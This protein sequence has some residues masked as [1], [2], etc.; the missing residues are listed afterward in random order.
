MLRL[1]ATQGAAPAMQPNQNGSIVVDARSGG[2]IFSWSQPKRIIA[3]LV[4][5]MAIAAV[6]WV[7]P[8]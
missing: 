8:A 5:M 3:T 6:S 1:I 4:P 7:I 2:F